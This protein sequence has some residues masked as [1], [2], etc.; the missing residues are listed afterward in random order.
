V[1]FKG[2]GALLIQWGEKYTGN[3]EEREY[4]NT[5]FCCQLQKIMKQ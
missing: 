5:V 1:A 4:Q 3:N 2:K